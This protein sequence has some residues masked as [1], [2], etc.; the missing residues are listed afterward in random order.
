MD[1]HIWLLRCQNCRGEFELRIKPYE[2]IPEYLKQAVCPHCYKAPRQE[3]SF[4]A[5]S[6][7]QVIAYRKEAN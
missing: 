1:R 5:G 6:W 4:P 3:R 2:R 7:H